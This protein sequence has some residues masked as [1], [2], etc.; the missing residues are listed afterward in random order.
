MEVMWREIWKKEQ[1]SDVLLVISKGQW[2]G[3]GL[4]F[5]ALGECMEMWDL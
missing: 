4:G 1:R 5:V 2:K 3:S